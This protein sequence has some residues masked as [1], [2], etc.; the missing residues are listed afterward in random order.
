MFRLLGL[1]PGPDTTAAAAASLAGLDPGHARRLLRELTHAHL[2]TEHSPGRYTFHDLLRAY[3]AELASAGGERARL[4]ATV[5]MLDHY[6]HTAHTAAR[7]MQPHRA[8]P[9]LDPVNPGVTPE[10]LTEHHQALAWFAAEHRVLAAA[11][12]AA[13]EA[14][15]DVHAW[16]LPW[17][18][19]SFLDWRGHWH[20]W[21]AAQRAAVAAAIRLG[22]KT[23]EAMARRGTAAACLKIGD[24]EEARAHLAACLGL[25]RQLGDRVGEARIRQ[26]LSGAAEMQGGYADA[27]RHSEQALEL[28]RASDDRPGEA[29][30]LNSI[31]WCHAQ[32]GNLLQARTV[33]QQAL[34][35]YREL[36]NRYC[37]AH[38]WDSLGYAEL[39]LGHLANAAGCYRHALSL[40]RDV[41]D[42]FAEAD[43]LTHLGDARRAAGDPAE[44]RDAWRQALAI[45]DD[46]PHPDAEKVRA[47][48]A[49][50][51]GSAQPRTGHDAVA[52]TLTKKL[53][54]SRTASMNCSKSTGLVT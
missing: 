13:A 3:A 40:M 5:R 20:E 38:T 33:C 14:G 43:I 35:L 26:D 34:S 2:L 28:F 22:D 1:H 19:A 52:T 4:E 48:L 31:G 42:R 10:S 11:L 27:L 7:L 36:G 24:H 30:A 32:L 29:N 41:G 9:A 45:L 53:P 37:E 21:A 47:K 17:A 39:R 51:G 23:A 50:L 12:A 6:L 54:I 16:Q 44:A 18:L 8:A 25:Y 46:L 15:F 49:S